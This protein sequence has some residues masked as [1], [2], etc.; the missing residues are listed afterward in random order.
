[1][2]STPSRTLNPFDFQTTPT[3]NKQIPDS[4]LKFIKLIVRSSVRMLQSFPPG[5]TEKL[6]SYVY[7]LIDPFIN[8]KSTNYYTD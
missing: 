4:F 3:F 5:V 7:R 8:E 2:Q 1:L 6:K